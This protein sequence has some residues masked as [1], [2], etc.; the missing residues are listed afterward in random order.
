MSQKTKDSL[1][2]SQKVNDIAKKIELARKDIYQLSGIERN[3]SDQLEYLETLKKQL[4]LKKKLVAK[5][6]GLNLK[7]SGL[8]GSS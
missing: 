3:H 8:A 7:V 4:E 6:Q 1:E 5:Y 2:V